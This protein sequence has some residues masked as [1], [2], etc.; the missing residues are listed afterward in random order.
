VDSSVTASL[1]VGALGAERVVGLFMPEEDSDSESLRLGRLVA[2][3]LGIAT[4]LEDIGPLLRAAGFYQR[5]EEFIRQIV[6]KYGTGFRCKLVLGQRTA[7]GGYNLFALV[8]QA[9]DGTQQR[10]RLPLET[11]L[12]IVAATNMK[13]RTRKQLEYYHADRL[14]FVAA[15]TPNRLEHDQGF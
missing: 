4:E 6:P 13:Q 12:G 1:C 7:D 2:R 15:G 9:P 8:V 14:H 5:R 10:V 3:A 11:Y